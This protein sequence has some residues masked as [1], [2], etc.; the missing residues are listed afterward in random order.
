MFGEKRNH[1]LVTSVVQNAKGE[2]CSGAMIPNYT[3]FDGADKN[4]GNENEELL[5]KALYYITKGY[6]PIK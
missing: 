2:T 6:F 5:K 3:T 1:R 4:W